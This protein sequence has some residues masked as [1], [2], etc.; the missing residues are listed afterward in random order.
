MN[1]EVHHFGDAALVDPQQG[2]DI[3]LGITQPVDSPDA[4]GHFLRN[5]RRAP[6]RNYGDPDFHRG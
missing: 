5:R 3:V 1:L 2:S 4:S 6:V